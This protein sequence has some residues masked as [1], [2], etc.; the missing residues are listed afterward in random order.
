[1]LFHT[2]GSTLCRF[3]IRDDSNISL[4]I[5][6][7]IYLFISLTLTLPCLFIFVFLSF[8][9]SFS[10]SL[11]LSL[12]LSLCLTVSMF[13]FKYEL[14]YHGYFL[15]L[16]LFY[17]SFYGQL[18][19]L[20]FSMNIIYLISVSLYFSFSHT[21]CLSIYPTFFFLSFISPFLTILSFYDSLFILKAK[22]LYFQSWLVCTSLP[23]RFWFYITCLYHP[24]FFVLLLP[25]SLSI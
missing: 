5:Y 22:L 18:L 14:F 8:F 19:K 11:S 13:L 2:K 24:Y 1:M 4:Y 15:H 6:L 9:L 25:F 10:L 7:S 12:L 21:P 20:R 17:L 16:G 3:T 23:L